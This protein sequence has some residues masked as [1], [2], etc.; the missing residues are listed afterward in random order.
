VARPP[1]GPPPA[2]ARQSADEAPSPDGP[3]CIPLTPFE[4]RALAAEMQAW[5]GELGRAQDRTNWPYEYYEEAILEQLAGEGDAEAAFQLAMNYRWRFL[6]PGSGSSWNNSAVPDSFTRTLQLDDASDADSME[7]ARDA[8][9]YYMLAATGGYVFAIEEMGLFVDELGALI[10]AAGANLPDD[11]D[12][13]KA[14]RLQLLEAALAELR[15]AS[16]ALAEVPYMI[17]P[18]LAGGGES[19]VAAEAEPSLEVV[20]MQN[21]LITAFHEMRAERGLPPF[22][23]SIPPGVARYLARCQ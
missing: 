17:M 10:A 16:S 9:S 11:G 14:T 12:G 23:E 2:S 1:A 4:E 3:D 8:A 21:M 20:Q 15:Q 19:P 13:D 7:L 6:Y 22:D 5:S 18:A